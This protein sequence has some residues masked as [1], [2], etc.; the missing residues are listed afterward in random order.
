MEVRYKLEIIGNYLVISDLLLEELITSLPCKDIYYTIER[1]DG[2]FSDKL[3]FNILGG[4]GGTIKFGGFDFINNKG[5]DNIS[6]VNG[7]SVGEV[8]SFLRNNTGGPVII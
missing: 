6:T 1:R 4:F 3:F 2:D 7:T 5:E 8:I